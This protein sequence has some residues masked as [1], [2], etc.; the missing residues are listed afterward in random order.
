MSYQDCVG[1]K[2]MQL[3][4]IDDENAKVAFGPHNTFGRNGYGVPRVVPPSPS[5]VPVR[6]ATWPGCS[7]FIRRSM[8]RNRRLTRANED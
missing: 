2:R 4:A 8:E 3:D 5:T 7:N 1:L 6:G